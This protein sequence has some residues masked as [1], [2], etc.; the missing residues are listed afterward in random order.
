MVW[1]QRR[2]SRRNPSVA[3]LIV[4][5][6]SETSHLQQRR[7]SVI[8]APPQDSAVLRRVASFTLDRATLDCHRSSPKP[9]HVAQ[10]IDLALYE[11][12]EGKHNNQ[13]IY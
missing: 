7:Y 12:F 10:K 8:E 3:T 6:T 2:T 4:P 5:G 11:T 9:K 1:Y 13:F